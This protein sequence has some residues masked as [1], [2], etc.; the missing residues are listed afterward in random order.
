KRL[1]YYILTENGRG[2]SY[3]MPR[4]L[5]EKLINY[6]WPGNIRELKNVIERLCFLADGTNLNLNDLP[7]AILNSSEKKSIL[8]VSHIENDLLK[9]PFITLKE[10]EKKYI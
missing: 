5:L 6:H 2:M 10:L 4:P 9:G 1:I 7:E 8:T 3:N